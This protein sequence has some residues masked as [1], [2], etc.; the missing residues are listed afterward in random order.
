MQLVANWPYQK[1]IIILDIIDIFCSKQLFVLFGAVQNSLNMN[2]SS[3]SILFKK[4][5]HASRN[6]EAFITLALFLSCIFLEMPIQ[7][8]THMRMTIFFVVSGYLINA[9]SADFCL[10]ADSS[11]SRLFIMI[12]WSLE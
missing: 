10:G 12:M 6:E 11:G 5:I 8:L 1:F 9:D 2:K 7:Q 4:S 3:F